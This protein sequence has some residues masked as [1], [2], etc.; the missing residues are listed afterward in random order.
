[1]N[2]HELYAYFTDSD[3]LDDILFKFPKFAAS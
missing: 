2:F 3:V 1:M